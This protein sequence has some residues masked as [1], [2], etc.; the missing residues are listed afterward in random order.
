VCAHCGVERRALHDLVDEHDRGVYKRVKVKSYF[1][2]VNGK[3]VNKTPECK[4]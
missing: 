3:L 4:A 1:Y 2:L